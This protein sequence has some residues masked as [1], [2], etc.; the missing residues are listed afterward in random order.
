[1]PPKPYIT[2]GPDPTETAAERAERKLFEKY[3]PKKTD[4]SKAAQFSHQPGV[5]DP[6]ERAL[7]TG[8]RQG[9]TPA[10]RPAASF[11]IPPPTRKPAPA[12]GG[13]GLE[14][15]AGGGGG[16]GGGAGMLNPMLAAA[17]KDPK[18]LT[19]MVNMGGTSSF[20]RQ[21]VAPVGNMPG[22]QRGLDISAKAEAGAIDAQAKAEQAKA[23][24]SAA[25]YE[26]HVANLR[27]RQ[28]A[29]NVLE[30]EVEADIAEHDREAAQIRADLASRKVDPD[31]WWSKKT[32]GQ[33]VGYGIAIALAGLG[34]AIAGRDGPNV[35]IEMMD[36]AV[37]QDIQ[38]QKDNILKR[39]G[40]LRDVQGVLAGL[41]RRLGDMRQAESQARIMLKE[42]LAFK[43]EKITQEANNPIIKSRAMGA[44]AKIAKGLLLEKNAAWQAT[45]PRTT[46][47]SS[48]SNQRVPLF[49]LL[50][51]QMAQQ[52]KAG[53][54]GKS[55]DKQTSSKLASVNTVR[56]GMAHLMHEIKKLKL[57][58]G[59]TAWTGRDADAV[60]NLRKLTI[61]KIAVAL[62]VDKAAMLEMLKGTLGT[63]W[64]TEDGV[65]YRINN[66]SHALNSMEE[67]L[68]TSL[69]NSGFN[70]RPHATHAMKT[71]RAFD[72]A[73][74]KKGGGH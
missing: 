42:Q 25:A 16:G 64:T 5:T 54:P 31:S 1:M 57:P 32:T 10:H 46:T 40:D 65:K 69:H 37:D 30:G 74:G 35:V 49:K 7:V 33:R 22:L 73:M 44:K 3:G 13:G 38:A 9:F 21:T 55:L 62:G 61:D 41:F 18:S 11:T 47:S 14:L 59:A 58:A 26:A 50:Q 52:K 6:R 29:A 48:G 39:R 56:K 72:L 71:R 23:D 36:R 34:K 19:K 12:G 70:V 20:T 51:A 53:A 17:L 68:L 2:A 8:Q 45:R 24:A 43:L 28:T 60:E 67:E 27:Q 63:K 66:M 4:A 15:L